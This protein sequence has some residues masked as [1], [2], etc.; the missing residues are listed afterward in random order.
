VI[1]RGAAGRFAYVEVKRP[2]RRRMH[3]LEL[4]TGRTVRTLPAREIRLL[5]R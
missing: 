4:D 2:G 3:V 1:V 5:D